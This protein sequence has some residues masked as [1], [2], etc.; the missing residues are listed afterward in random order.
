MV[1][2]VTAGKSSH[3]R[4]VF[5]PPA[6]TRRRS[7]CRRLSMAHAS[8]FVCKIAVGTSTF[9]RRCDEC[10]LLA[11]TSDV[12]RDAGVTT[13]RDV[14]LSFPFLLP[15]RDTQAAGATPTELPTRSSHCNTR[16]ESGFSSRLGTWDSTSGTSHVSSSTGSCSRSSSELLGTTYG[17]YGRR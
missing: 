7:S 1:P 13:Y 10:L 4:T 12:G 16:S 8:E 15:Q 5:N 17:R 3:T 6:V 9:L 11:G 2:S 14:G